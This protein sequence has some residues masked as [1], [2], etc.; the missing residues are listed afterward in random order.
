MGINK[1][2]NRRSK[3][4]NRNKNNRITRKRGGNPLKYFGFGSKKTPEPPIINTTVSNPMLEPKFSESVITPPDNNF[5][6]QFVTSNGKQPSQVQEREM[7]LSKQ[8][9]DSALNTAALSSVVLT[10]S[11]IGNVAVGAL[12]ATG[13]GVPLAGLIG[14][15]LI[16]AQVMANMAIANSKLKTVL[17]DVLNIIMHCNKINQVIVLILGEFNVKII[18]GTKPYE[19]DK[20][21][22]DRLNEKLELLF[23]YLLGIGEKQMIKL[24]YSSFQKLKIEDKYF[25]F[26]LEECIQRNIQITQEQGDRIK[27]SNSTNSPGYLERKLISVSRMTN[28]TVWAQYS[29]NEIVKDLAIVNGYFM[30]MKSQFDMIVHHCER[31]I[32]DKTILDGIWGNIMKDDVYRSYLSLDTTGIQGSMNPLH[33]NP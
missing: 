7:S 20:E 32:T 31:T 14:A 21:I 30:L 29:I 8:A 19:I 10:G 28:R 23:T 5:N 9:S 27:K 13:V 17:Y 24:L 1:T 16:V 2:K 4:K 3:Y 25:D 22:L 12:A 18:N 6:N 26:I 15:I 11:Y 33:S